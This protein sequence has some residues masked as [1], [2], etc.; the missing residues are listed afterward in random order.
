[1]V[2]A[3]TIKK[4]GAGYW[5]L[6][7]ADYRQLC[8]WTG[9][10]LTVGELR[11]EVEAA[12][13][14]GCKD[15]ILKVVRVESARNGSVR[16]D[17]FVD[18]TRCDECL[19]RLKGKSK[20]K[21][22][23]VR[24][25]RTYRERA[26]ARARAGVEPARLGRP[27][28]GSL[29]LVS[30]NVCG[31]SR[32]KAEVCMMA[33]AEQAD[34][35]M[36]QETLWR[37][38]GWGLTVPGYTVLAVERDGE[39]GSGRRGV[40]LAVRAGVL[41]VAIENTQSPYAVFAKVFHEGQMVVVGSVYIPNT[42]HRRKEGITAVRTAVRLI[43]QRWPGTPM[44]LGGD[45]NMSRAQLANYLA[46]WGVPL[47][48]KDVSGSPAT[49]H[50]GRVR[51]ALDHFVVSHGANGQTSKTRVN[52]SWDISD[53]WPIRLTMTTKDDWTAR[54]ER[55]EADKKTARVSAAK[56]KDKAKDIY[57]HN[58]FKVLAD[59]LEP[60]DPDNEPDLERDVEQLVE[61]ATEALRDAKAFVRPRR[62]GESG[63]SAHAERG[64]VSKA[65]VKA[66]DRRRKAAARLNDAYDKD[67]KPAVIERLKREHETLR[68][69]A[70]SRI[71][72]DREKSWLQ[73][74]SKGATLLAENNPR[75]FWRWKKALL[76]EG[77]QLGRHEMAPIRDPVTDT[78]LLDPELI[79]KAWEEHYTGLSAD[80]TG[81]SRDAEFWKG[82][83]KG[84]R[85]AR[86]PGLNHDPSWIELKGVIRG[87]KNGKAPGDSGLSAEFF[88]LVL[89]E[90]EGKPEEAPHP[91]TPLGAAVL[92]I[93]RRMFVEGFVPD[94]INKASV[95]SIPKKGD[96][97]VIDN[98][99]G[100]SLMEVLL[101][102]V[103]T[104]VVRRISQGL[105]ATESLVREQAGF[106]PTQECAAQVISLYEVCRR[107]QIKGLPT[108]VAFLDFRKAYDTVPHEALMAKLAHIGVRGKS[109]RF[110]RALYRNSRLR[111]RVGGQTTPE[112]PLLR[113]SRQGCPMSPTL[114][115]VFINDIFDECR[116]LGAFVPGL[117]R[118]IPGLL[119][120]DDSA[121]IAGSVADLEAMLMKVGDWA[122]KWEMSF[123]IDK[124]GVMSIGGDEAELRGAELSLQGEQL[125]LVDTYV[126]LGVPFNSNLD[127]RQI[128]TVRAAKAKASVKA[129]SGLLRSASI[130]LAI[131]INIVKSCIVSRAT[132]GGELLGMQL[133]RAAPIQKVLDEALR[134]VLQLGKT[135]G[136][137]VAMSREFGV[138]SADAAMA[139]ARTRAFHKFASLPTWI[140]RLIAKPLGANHETWVTGTRRWLWRHG[141]SD[142]SDWPETEDDLSAK[143]GARVVKK[144]CDD[145]RWQRMLKRASKLDWYDT[146]RFEATNRYIR[147]TL[148]Q[149]GLA[150]GAR[151]LARMRVGAYWTGEKAAGAKLIDKKYKSICISCGE[152]QPETVQHIL[153]ECRRW[154]E[155]RKVMIGRLPEGEEFDVW[156]GTDKDRVVWLL[157][158]EADGESMGATWARDNPIEDRNDPGFWVAVS[159][160]LASIHK[161]HNASLWG[162]T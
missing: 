88:K 107:R 148:A 42:G 161:E 130:P 126:Y 160:F 99:R 36:M 49:F 7:G 15:A 20:Q 34:V 104:L 96:P 54:R 89:L 122:S 37:N 114:F 119:Y 154:E 46:R 116:D 35:I 145:N 73:C 78:L 69:K 98:Y 51:T 146:Y 18:Q 64:F 71:R 125:P 143:A 127:L 66:V 12:V 137:S 67:A 11:M 92:S 144:W 21:S 70:Q 8:L 1:L 162:A 33:K 2:Q 103:C 40:A 31:L 41:A 91:E 55:A 83:C 22:W 4:K 16:Y 132:Y 19:G 93:A 6:R 86:L 117:E 32:K 120:A 112:I 150:L 151:N 152:G 100:I 110:I 133:Q 3:P 48:V 136:N 147:Y 53:H 45:W 111:V 156:R 50:R 105:E 95:V 84:R 79:L 129:L 141:P 97:T 138:P 82:K 153:F 113:G 87:M 90:D 128:A 131:K 56:L 157:G 115:D 39:E 17:I 9:R 24:A 121:V 30:L 60:E 23:Y 74:V 118:R 75:A 149:P 5:G 123:K 72:E 101:K 52:R 134:S 26:A 38:W 102:I 109:L 58:R 108:Y 106:R 135:V 63:E 61:A 59:L 44:V 77:R 29:N 10:L 62:P 57:G 13:G 76:G 81:H 80:L 65:A 43:H 158:G 139:A 94:C 140:G 27:H 14:G 159:S 28:G 68:D 124:C 85:K 142:L 47:L 155:A 25:H